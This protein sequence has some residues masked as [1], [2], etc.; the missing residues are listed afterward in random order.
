[1]Q[2]GQWDVLCPECGQAMESRHTDEAV[3]NCHNQYA[4]SKYTQELISLRLGKRYEIPTVAMRYSITQG[5]RQSPHNAYSGIL[6]IFTTRLLNGLAPIVYEDGNQLRD[7]VSVFDVARANLLVMQ[8]PC[9][10][11]EAYNVGSGQPTT[12]LQ[13][14]QRLMETVGVDFEPLVLGQFRVGDTRHIVSNVDKLR[15]CGWEPRVPL[16]E[17]MAQYVDWVRESRAAH[18]SFLEADRIMQAAGVVQNS[19]P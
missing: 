12:V 13:Y 3:V 10:D 11:F 5:P 6:R 2:A 4:I 14:A 16:Q 17:I 7:Y 8:D 9:T 19:L 15:G 18:R 1:M